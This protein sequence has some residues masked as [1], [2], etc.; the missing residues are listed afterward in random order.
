MRIIIIGRW[1]QGLHGDMDRVAF[2][3]AVGGD[4][5]NLRLY[6]F[7]RWKRRL[8]AIQLQGMV[9]CRRHGWH[10]VIV[11]DF[12]GNRMVHKVRPVHVQRAAIVT[13]LIAVRAVSGREAV[14]RIEMG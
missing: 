7:P 12:A 1:R 2:L 11:S 6:N 5:G 9:L 4:N 13:E 8:I 14:S 10:R 3:L